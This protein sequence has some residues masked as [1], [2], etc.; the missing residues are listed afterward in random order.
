MKL[1]AHEE[2]G[3]R[4]LL[5]LGRISQPIGLTIPE[6]S[7]SQGI[8]EPYV[9]KLLRMLRLG[10]FVKSARGR[11]GGYTLARPAGRIVLGDVL[12]TLGGRLVEE[13]FC[14]RFSPRQEHCAQACECSIRSLWDTL[15][16]AVDRVLNTLTLADLLRPAPGFVTLSGERESLRD[17]RRSA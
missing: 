7:R 3:L 11:A 9:A 5:E 14:G 1:T 6:I 2:Y 12:A 10:G 15:Q 16:L 8:S 17:A 4:C 13:D